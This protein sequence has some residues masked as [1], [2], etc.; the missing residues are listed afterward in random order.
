MSIKV[1]LSKQVSKCIS[2][3]STHWP[4]VHGHLWDF[5]SFFIPITLT[6]SYHCLIFMWLISSAF[7]VHIIIITSH[8]FIIA[9]SSYNTYKICSLFS[10]GNHGNISF[11]QCLKAKIQIHFSTVQVHCTKQIQTYMYL[12]PPVN[13]VFIF[14]P[15]FSLISE[16]WPLVDL[17]DLWPNQAPVSL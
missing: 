11:F 12:L 16:I 5:G 14:W 7:M 10:L 8:S 13:K 15:I 4:P 9:F 6:K 17:C 1:S 2:I 3:E